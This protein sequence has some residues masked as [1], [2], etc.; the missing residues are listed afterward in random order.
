MTPA[1][2]PGN[3]ALAAGQ[4]LEV[5]FAGPITG[6]LLDVG[7]NDDNRLDLDFFRGEQRLGSLSVPAVPWTGACYEKPGIQSRLLSLPANLRDR[8]WD[9]VVVRPRPGS[10]PVRLAHV[11]VFAEGIPGLEDE[12]P[13]VIPGRLRMESEELLPI[14]PGTPY[15][16]DPDPSASGGRARRA[17]VDFACAVSHTPRLF[18]PRGSYRLECTLKVDDN[19]GG[20]EVAALCAAYPH[21]APPAERHLRAAD[22]PA[23]GRYASHSLTFEVTD[24][25]GGIVLGIRTTGR[26]PVTVDYMDLI[27]EPGVRS[28][29]SANLTPDS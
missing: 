9:R 26:T 13:A 3:V 21:P 6:R 19:A 28:Q 1:D 23:A 8:P 14:N 5:R 12:R 15:T 22:F 4:P 29:E 7:A 17:A 18:L 2:A 20:A 11:L 10:Q 27:A 16:D 25:E 24:E